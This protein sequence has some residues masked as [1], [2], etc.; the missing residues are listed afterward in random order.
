VRNRATSVLNVCTSIILNNSLHN[1]IV[2]VRGFIHCE[3][4]RSAPAVDD[5]M[6]NWPRHVAGVDLVR[7]D[8]DRVPDATTD[9]VYFAWCDCGW[10]GSDQS[11]EAAARWEAERHTPNV[12]AGLSSLIDEAR[13]G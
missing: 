2:G 12:Q 5:R 8:D 13:A 6:A 11:S 4:G 3:S 7:R 10:T 1:T 9:L